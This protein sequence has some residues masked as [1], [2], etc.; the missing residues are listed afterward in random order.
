MDIYIGNFVFEIKI[1]LRND[2][3]QYIWSFSRSSTFMLIF[4]DHPENKI[5]KGDFRI[6]I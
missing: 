4:C 6:I 3:Q 5:T 2:T 1:R